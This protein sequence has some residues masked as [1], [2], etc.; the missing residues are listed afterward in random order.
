M[1]PLYLWCGRRDLNP[2]SQ[3]WKTQS[4][5]FEA[6]D[7]NGFQNFMLQKSKSEYGKYCVNYAQ[8]Y[9]HCL[10]NGNFSEIQSLPKT[11]RGNV[12]RALANLSKYLGIYP[13]FQNLMRSHGIEWGGKSSDQIVI[14]RLTKTK[15]VDEMFEWI[16]QVKNARR[17]L[18]DFMDFMAISGMRLVEAIAS[19]NLIIDLA[20]KNRLT[21][22]YNEEK[23]TLE[24]YRFKDIFLRRSKK[25]FISFIPKALIEKI[26]LNEPLPTSRY[27]VEERIR[28]KGLP[29]RFTDIRELTATFLI[30]H[31]RREEIDFIQGRVSSNVFM[32]HYFNPAL[33]SDLK[34]R[35]FKAIKEIETKIS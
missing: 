29:L 6:I 15:D 19:Y 23:E 27:A 21:E 13:Q 9:A 32:E 5:K 17:D 30:K 2:G 31:L 4:L 16:R 20:R 25:V 18:A 3:A 1:K 12:V 7:W 26:V 8:K 28:K 34:E 11:V 14:E 24:H 22:Y 35:V 33:I 10:L